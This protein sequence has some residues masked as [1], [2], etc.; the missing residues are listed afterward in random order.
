MWSAS[1]AVEDE[2][3]ARIVPLQARD[4]GHRG[5]AGWAARA[6]GLASARVR[7]GY[8]SERARARLALWWRVTAL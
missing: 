7:D 2:G 8:T 3:L 5:G 6:R 1:H 4:A